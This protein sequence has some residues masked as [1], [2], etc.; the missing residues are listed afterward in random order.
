[1]FGDIADTLL[2][3]VE[4]PDVD[5]CN[6]LSSEYDVED[7]VMGGWAARNGFAS[8]G[9]RDFEVAAEEADVTALLDQAHGI[10]WC[11]LKGRDGLDIVARAKLRRHRYR[12]PAVL[13][14]H[15]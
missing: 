9:F 3:S 8:E 13:Q 7:A 6:R 14:H 12:I 4:R 2:A 10:A 5:G 1:M 15:R 11:V